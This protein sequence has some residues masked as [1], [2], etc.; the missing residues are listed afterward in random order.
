M[1]L[2][3]GIFQLVIM[4][5]CASIE[6]VNSVQSTHDLS[7]SPPPVFKPESALSQGQLDLVFSH[8]PGQ[9]FLSRGCQSTE[10]RLACPAHKVLIVESAH[11]SPAQWTLAPGLTKLNCSSQTQHSAATEGEVIIEHKRD[12]R[13]IR[14]ALNRRCSGYSS[15]EECKFSLLL[16]QPESLSWGEGWVEILHKCVDQGHITTKCGRVRQVHRGYIMSKAYPKYYMGG[17]SCTWHISVPPSQVLLLRVLDLQ[18]RGLSSEGVCDDSV[19]IDYKAVVCGELDS[20]FHY[21]SNIGRAVITFKTA[22]DSQYIY[23]HRGFLVEVIPV[24]CSPLLPSSQSKA[25]LVYHNQTHATFQCRGRYVFSGSLSPTTTLLCTGHEY[26]A[27]LPGCVSITHLLT[28]ANV[29]VVHALLSSN[30]THQPIP[31]IWIHEVLL[32]LVFTISTLV[33]SLTGLI[34]LLLMKKHIQSGPRH[35]DQVWGIN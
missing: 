4:S 30:K 26:H 11:F 33:L 29:S 25:Y 17:Q 15:G 5:T 13:D 7:Q 16:D 14:Q 20:Q 8:P 19:T 23:P 31:T 34:I 21:I 35:Q 3:P 1:E 6:V 32:P 18:L 22:T 27:P 24:G 12:V 9:L 2:T 10:L 28:I